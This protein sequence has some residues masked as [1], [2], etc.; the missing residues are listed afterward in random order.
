MIWRLSKDKQ[1]VSLFCFIV[2]SR[3]KKLSS[4]FTEFCEIFEITRREVH[5]K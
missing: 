3:M 2:S 1:E 5:F 4:K